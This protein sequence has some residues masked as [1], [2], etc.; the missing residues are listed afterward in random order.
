MN[1][2]YSDELRSDTIIF[3]IPLM[4]LLATIIGIV[5]LV[6]NLSGGFAQVWVWLAIIAIS[7]PT[8][9]YSWRL[10]KQGSEKPGSM[11][12]LSVHMGLMTMALTRTWGILNPNPLPYFFAI[13]IIVASMTLS[14]IAGFKNWFACVALL[15]LGV[16]LAGGLTWPVLLR[17]SLPIGFNLLV[18]A[19]MY[20]SAMEWQYAVE[21]VSF[22]HIRAQQRRDELF[23]IK[24]EISST[25]NRLVFLNQQLDQARQQA[26]NERDLRTR[27]MNNVSHEL[28]TPMNAIVNFAHIL[29]QGGAGSVNSG[30]QDYLERIE[31][32]GWHLLDMLNDLL[33][34]AQIESGE[35]KLY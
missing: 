22:L 25:N 28:R 32:S 17:L 23:A 12:F 5:G 15:I 18:A 29:I 34:M 2:E 20:F 11:L 13:F 4:V 30:Q 16:Y 21:S 35:F 1:Q 31:K 19:A 8:G 9:R 33:D 7:L 6:G 27:F 26:I 14:P 3:I 24:E 10:I